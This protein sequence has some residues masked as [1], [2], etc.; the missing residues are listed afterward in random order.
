MRYSTAARSFR[1]AKLLVW[2][3]ARIHNYLQLGVKHIQRCADICVPKLWR[4]V[5]LWLCPRC[6]GF[7][8]WEQR[9]ELI[10]L[11]VYFIAFAL[12]RT[13]ARANR[14][15]LVAWANARPQTPH[16]PATDP[17]RYRLGA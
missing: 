6:F 10:Q 14:V 7:S 1:S 2:S 17:Y 5:R 9:R 15:R 12:H 13:V 16:L 3:A 8:R 11:I 4:M